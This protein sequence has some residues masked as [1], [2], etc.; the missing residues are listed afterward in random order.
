MNESTQPP[1]A[2][3]AAQKR[4]FYV[5]VHYTHR[6]GL[7]FD[8]GPIWETSDAAVRARLRPR[9]DVG[10]VSVEEVRPNKAFLNSDAWW[11]VI[12]A[13]D[14]SGEAP[15][16]EAA[17]T[18]TPWRV[19]DDG[20]SWPY[21]HAEHIPHGAICNLSSVDP[22]D[23]GN[24]DRSRKLAEANAAFIV[25]ACNSHARL[26]AENKALREAL[27]DLMAAAREMFG[28]NF[29]VTYHEQE[30]AEFARR[31]YAKLFRAVERAALASTKTGGCE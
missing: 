25:E 23:E 7:P 20:Q 12:Q 14:A 30:H 5:E 1:A 31:D 18:P 8:F 16:G 22:Q 19:I 17:H 10:R 21:V 11:A 9:G 13:K 26:T 28:E 3:E 6:A 24:G 29:D 2:G 4:K 27:T 15:A